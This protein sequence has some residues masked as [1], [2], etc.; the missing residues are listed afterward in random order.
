MLKYKL[1]LHLLQSFWTI[2]VIL[3]YTSTTGWH[4][5]ENL[6]DGE[7]RVEVRIRSGRSSEWIWMVSG[8][9][10][11]SSGRGAH[12]Y[13]SMQVRTVLWSQPPRRTSHSITLKQKSTTGLETS[14]MGILGIGVDV[15]HLPRIA[16]LIRRRTAQKLASRIL[17]TREW[18][19][20]QKISQ[21]DSTQQVQFLAVR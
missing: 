7:M 15:V 20:W 2:I 1:L 3:S 21:V 6:R 10:T 11:A 16:A 12:P 18:E 17:S 5:Y 13:R 9:W 14:G 4:V 19:D 8:W